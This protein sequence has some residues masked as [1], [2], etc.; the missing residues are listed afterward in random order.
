MK[1]LCPEEEV[2]ADYLENHLS[3][4]ERSRLEIYLSEC[5]ECLEELLAAKNLIQNKGLLEYDPV[6]KRI[7]ERAIH[8]LAERIPASRRSVKDKILQPVK[9]LRTWIANLNNVKLYPDSGFAHVRSYDLASHAGSFRTRKS[10]EK[11]E[12]EIEVEKTGN[13]SAVIRVHLVSDAHKTSNIRVTLQNKGQRE[14]SSFLLTDGF[15]VFEDILFGQYNLVFLRNGA[16]IGIYPFEIKGAYNGERKNR[17][18]RAPSRQ[19]GEGDAGTG[20]P[21]SNH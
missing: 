19:D 9:H 10:F 17:E 6:P 11:I 15:A 14:I 21:R 4:D 18:D 8:L 1:K 3:D 2:L 7:T 12:T 20:T 16:T 5:D 13:A